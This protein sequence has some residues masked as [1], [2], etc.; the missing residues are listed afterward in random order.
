MKMNKDNDRLYNT[1]FVYSYLIEKFLIVYTLHQNLSLDETM[2]SWH[3]KLKFKT[4]NP[5]KL[6][7]YKILV[8]V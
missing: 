7:K 1:E 8:R 5:R 6:T 2:I 3:G 4:N